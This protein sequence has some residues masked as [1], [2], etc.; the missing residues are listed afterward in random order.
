MNHYGSM[1]FRYSIDFLFRC[2]IEGFLKVISSYS[3]GKVVETEIKVF[4]LDLSGD[5]TSSMGY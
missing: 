2:S 3:I 4:L 5:K 1:C